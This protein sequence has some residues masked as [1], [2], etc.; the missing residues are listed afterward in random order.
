MAAC[1]LGS[2]TERSCHLSP[3][4]R[5]GARLPG[6]AVGKASSGASSQARRSSRPSLGMVRG[7]PAAGSP[8]GQRGRPLLEG[9][10]GAGGGTVWGHGGHP[11]THSR[12]F[13]AVEIPLFPPFTGWQTHSPGAMLRSAP[14]HLPPHPA[15]S[16]RAGPTHP[17]PRTRSPGAAEG[18]CSQLGLGF[19]VSS[20]CC[21]PREGPASLKARLAFF[22]WLVVLFWLGVFFACCKLML[23]ELNTSP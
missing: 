17:P 11:E 12:I 1:P 15:F 18:S 3:P 9:R 7:P 20:S 2:P 6:A 8:A 23:T 14:P 16:P 13:Q 4:R 22:F 19:G 21:R 10:P 5:H